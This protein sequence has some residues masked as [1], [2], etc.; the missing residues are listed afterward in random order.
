M[1]NALT[2]LVT[3]QIRPLAHDRAG[4]RPRLVLEV[5][6]LATAEDYG[7][8]DR[9][10]RFLV[11]EEP[12]GL[13][14][15]RLGRPGAD[16]D[17]TWRRRMVVGISADNHEL[18]RLVAVSRDRDLDTMDLHLLERAARIAALALSKGPGD[19][20]GGDQVPGRVPAGRARGAGR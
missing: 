4:D 9:A 8:F 17:G 5:T 16:A 6:A 20:A 12:L 2:A 18:G 13:R 10:G 11:E 7:C 15:E 1:V 3:S 19:R 14:A